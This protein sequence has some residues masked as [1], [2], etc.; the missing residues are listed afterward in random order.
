MNI[1]FFFSGEEF[2]IPVN[3]EDAPSDDLELLPHVQNTYA[4]NDGDKAKRG[5]TLVD[6]NVKDA[7]ILECGLHLKKGTQK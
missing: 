5:F 2:N 6:L 4:E 7:V 1:A 3:I